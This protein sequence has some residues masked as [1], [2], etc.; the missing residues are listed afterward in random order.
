MAVDAVGNIRRLLSTRAVRRNAAVTL[1]GVDEVGLTSLI[2]AVSFGEA[3]RELA[4]ELPAQLGRSAAEIV[5]IARAVRNS[6]SVLT[7]SDESVFEMR[8][9]RAGDGDTVSGTAAAGAELGAISLTIDQLAVGQRNN[10]RPQSPEAASP[11][12][13]GTSTIAIDIDGEAREI[14]LGVDAGESNRAVLVTTAEAINRSDVGVT[15]EAAVT[16]SGRVRLSIARSDTGIGATFAIRDVQGNLV[17]ATRA[18]RVEREAANAQFSINGEVFE[19]ETNR[20]ELDDGELT[21]DFHAVTNRGITVE[22]GPDVESQSRAIKAF[23]DRFNDLRSFLDVNGV[24][25]NRVAAV[26]LEGSVGRKS[27]ELGYVGILREADGSLS[28]DEER[29]AQVLEAE[30]ERARAALAGTSGIAVQAGS[31]A[32]RISTTSPVEFTRGSIVSRLVQGGSQNFNRQGA[33][34]GGRLTPVFAAGLIFDRPV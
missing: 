9:L 24:Y 10:S 33:L 3:P 30:S 25:F 23:V 4:P 12:E 15:A 19:A 21:L 34:V 13:A 26:L 1:R 14:A 29:L 2:D 20:V 32:E 16:D 5:Q 11:V 7:G 22:V 6:T 28:V 18:E 27:F 8:S 17:S 31:L